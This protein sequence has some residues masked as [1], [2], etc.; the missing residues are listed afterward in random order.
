MSK[1]THVLFLAAALALSVGNAA[2][3]PYSFTNITTFFCCGILGGPSV[4]NGGTVAFGVFTGI[5]LGIFTA[6]DRPTTMEH[7]GSGALS[8][9]ALVPSSLNASGTLAF[10]ARHTPLVDREGI[11]TGSGGPITTIADTS[12]PFFFGPNGDPSLSLNDNGTVAFGAANPDTGE[13]GIFTGSGGA[14]TTIADTSGPFSDVFSPS[15]NESGTVAFLA[16]LKTGEQGIFTGSGGRTTTIADSSGPFSR[17]FGGFVGGPSLNDSGTVAFVGVLDTGEQGIFTS[18]GGAI[19]TL[20][21]TSGP[22]AGFGAL[23]LNDNGTVAFAASLDTG[24]EGIFTGSGGPTTTIASGG[25]FDFLFLDS[26]SINNNGT[27]A[28]GRGGDS[29]SGIFIGPE[30]FAD[31][32]ILER[33]ALFGSS[34]SFAS[35][36]TQSLNDAG[37]ISFLYQLDDGRAG[38]ARADP[39][40]IRVPEP[41][42]LFLLVAGLLAAVLWRKG[43]ST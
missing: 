39:L 9:I 17:F 28:F 30:P 29:L 40:V 3:V 1:R 5:D 13:Q 42:T 20:Y 26:L 22:F 37:Q 41:G 27:V 12:G 23:S 15:L 31:D 6:R 2:A 24:E 34:L 11:F 18:S 35:M 8:G 32:V 38:V 19:T 33:D 14:T 43:K 25:M 21:D 4:N 10:P 36:S 16:L 7:E